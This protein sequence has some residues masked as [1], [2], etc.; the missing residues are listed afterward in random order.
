MLPVIHVSFFVFFV[1]VTALFKR[2]KLFLQLRF[3]STVLCRA[4]TIS[5]DGYPESCPWF[6]KILFLSQLQH[7]PHL[8]KE[9]KFVTCTHMRQSFFHMF[10]YVPDQVQSDADSQHARWLHQSDQRHNER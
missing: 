6:C 8:M 5:H 7:Y 1:V 4:Q 10:N 2:D 9:C 3:V